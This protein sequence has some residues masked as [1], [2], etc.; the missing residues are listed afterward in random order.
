VL[1][2]GLTEG[3]LRRF[4]WDFF[5]DAAAGRLPPIVYIDPQFAWNDDHP[6]HHPGVGQ[7]LISA[8]H[9]V[10]ATSPHWP[11]CNLVITY[12][13]HGGF[14]DHVAPGLA[15]DGLALDGFDQLGFRVPGMVIGPYAKQGYVS[16]VARD[17]TSALKHI[18]RTFGTAPLTAR[19]EAA[20]DLEECLDL[21]RLAR[22]EPADPIT[23]P[24]VEVDESAVAEGCRGDSL[25]MKRG[26][27]GALRPWV[28]TLA[29]RLERRRPGLVVRDGRE[30]VYGI[31][32]WL[33]RR[34]LGRIRRGR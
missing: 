17:H 24:A 21:D 10:L 12:D 11:T 13:E 1:D 14:F 7:Q 16:S 4:A 23:V 2:D 26:A 25:S 33:D 5:D 34:G 22:G 19:S 28:G 20:N 30:Q 8:V 9:E 32:D 29:D 6:P 27:P 18:Q 15:P 3:K 31:A